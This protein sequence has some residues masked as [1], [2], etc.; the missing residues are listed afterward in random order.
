[1]LTQCSQLC[2]VLFCKIEIFLGR[3]FLKY[4]ITQFCIA[5]N[6]NQRSFSFELILFLGILFLAWRN[7][8]NLSGSCSRKVPYY[9]SKQL[10]KSYLCCEMTQISQFKLKILPLDDRSRDFHLSTD[11]MRDLSPLLFQSTVQ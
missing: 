8:A 1:M 4:L 6:F 9:Y 3:N 11:S 10:S 5:V 2:Y 7:V